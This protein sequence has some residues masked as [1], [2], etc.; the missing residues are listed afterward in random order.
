MPMNKRTIFYAIVIVVIIIMAVFLLKPRSTNEQTAID[1]CIQSGG[2][3]DVTSQTCVPG[4]VS[5]AQAAP[6]TSTAKPAPKPVAAV[7]ASSGYYSGPKPVMLP[8]YGDTTSST[9]IVLLNTPPANTSIASPMTITGEALG[10]WFSE[11]VFPIYL[12]DKNGRIL[13]QG[14]AKAQSDWMTSGFVPFTATL[15]FSRQASGSTGYLI[16]RKDNP[17][18]L[19]ANDAAVERQVMFQ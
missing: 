18:G 9:T 2:S 4:Q 10:R 1:A 14:Q 8:I 11:A 3:F 7:P 13:A 12:T 5:G 6:S 16:L 17:S 19:S 15:S